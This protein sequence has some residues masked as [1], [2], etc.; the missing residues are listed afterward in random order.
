MGDQKTIF[1]ETATKVIGNAKPTHDVKELTDALAVYNLLSEFNPNAGLDDITPLL[2]AASNEATKSLESVLNVFVD[3]FGVGG[4]VATGDRDALYQRIDNI[5]E[6]RLSNVSQ[7]QWIS[8]AGFIPDILASAAPAELGFIYALE[9]LNPFAVVNVDS[10]YTDLDP[11]KFS[12][13]YLLD[14]ATLLEDKLIRAVNDYPDTGVGNELNGQG[15]YAGKYLHL[16]DDETGFDTRKVN[17]APANLEIT[18]RF[19]KDDN[20]VVDALVGAVGEDRFYGRAGDDI[21]EGKRGNDYLEGGSGDDRYI[22]NIG[23]GVDTILDVEGNDRILLGS[24]NG[25]TLGGTFDSVLS[26]TNVYEDGDRNRYTV[27]G[28]DLQITL[29]NGA[30]LDTNSNIRIKNFTDGM[31]GINLNPIAAPTSPQ[32]PTGT[33]FFDLGQPTETEYVVSPTVNGPVE[34]LSMVLAPGPR[35]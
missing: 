6:F 2:K 28:T 9:K 35:I 14:R 31:F 3:L 4:K 7:A 27:S 5:A 17:G 32:A 11:S 26:Q 23:D 25:N 20:A 24:V 8:L 21:L 34:H 22:F 10:F 13:N 30:Q 1:S 12:N 18:L 29:F 16:V 33:Q 15:L 19:G